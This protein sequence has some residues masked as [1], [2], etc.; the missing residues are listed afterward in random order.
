MKKLTNKNVTTVVDK[1]PVKYQHGFT[2]SEI[3]KLLSDYEINEDSFYEYLGTN[4]CMIIEGQVITYHCDVEKA[5]ICVLE[6][7]GQNIWE[8]D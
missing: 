1:F 7:R 8:W 2:P 3:K 4:T 6:N 5:L